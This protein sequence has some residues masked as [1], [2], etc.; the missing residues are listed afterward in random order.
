MNK[1]FACFVL[2]SLMLAGIMMSACTQSGVIWKP[3]KGA[4]VEAKKEQKLILLKVTQDNCHYCT[5]MERN[6]LS[7]KAVKDFIKTNF[8]PVAVNISEEMLPLGLK[9]SMT[10][11]FFFIDFKGSVVKKV[12]GSWDQKD[13]QGFMYKAL[14]EKR[15]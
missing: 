7:Q 4:L 1:G 13:F 5:D 3:W 9:V 14:E 10:P 15:R 12:P 2:F 6:V 11:T 8:I